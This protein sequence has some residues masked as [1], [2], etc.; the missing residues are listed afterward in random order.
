V[1][2]LLLRLDPKPREVDDMMHGSRGVLMA[3]VHHPR[4]CILV[5]MHRRAGKQA[6]HVGAAAAAATAV[7]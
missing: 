4:R 3:G 2:H 7:G 6:R 5:P 1:C